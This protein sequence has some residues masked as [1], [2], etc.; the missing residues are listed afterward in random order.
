MLFI[1]RSNLF[2][3]RKESQLPFSGNQHMKKK[4][5]KNNVGF[6]IFMALVYL[7]IMRKSCLRCEKN[8]NKCRRNYEDRNWDIYFTEGI[9]FLI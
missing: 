6:I 4:F 1:L 8:L 5:Y 2:F 3:K 7:A 9:R